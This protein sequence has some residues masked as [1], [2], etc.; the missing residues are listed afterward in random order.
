MRDVATAVSI[1]DLGVLKPA[2][3][4]INTL[5]EGREPCAFF[6]MVHDVPILS[7]LQAPAGRL[8]DM[9]GHCDRLG[10]K[11]RKGRGQLCTGAPRAHLVPL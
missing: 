11:E 6:Y 8:P 5:S 4:Q 2:R 3:Y 9:W 7:Y 1:Q 10:V